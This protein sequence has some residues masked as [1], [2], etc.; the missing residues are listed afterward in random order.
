MKQI[1]SRV[2]RSIL[3]FHIHG[4]PNVRRLS[5]MS[6]SSEDMDW[7]LQDFEVI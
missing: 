1:M 7:D 2:N 6:E 5:S 4:N 3:L